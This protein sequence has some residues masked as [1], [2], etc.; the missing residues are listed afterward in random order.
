MRF[1]QL[2]VTVFALKKQNLKTLCPIHLQMYYFY[3]KPKL[4]IK[5]QILNLFHQDIRDLGRIETVMVG[6]NGYGEGLLPSH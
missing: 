6:D 3:V 5:Y 1:Y 4:M 2:I